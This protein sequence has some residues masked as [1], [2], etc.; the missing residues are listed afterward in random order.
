MMDKLLRWLSRRRQRR[1]HALILAEWDRIRPAL[2]RW[3]W[4]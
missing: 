1:V 2:G 3:M 4:R